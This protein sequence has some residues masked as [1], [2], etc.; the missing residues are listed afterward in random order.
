MEYAVVY[1][2]LFSLGPLFFLLERRAPAVAL[3]RT[4]AAVV[5]DGLYWLLTPIFTGTLSRGLVLGLVGVIG[6]G[7]GHGLD[8]FGFLARVQAAMPF[9]RLPLAA[10][11]VLALLVSDAIGY[12]SHRLRHGALLWNLHSVHHSA[13]ELTALAAARLHPLDEALDSMVMGVPVLLL[14]FP[15]EVFALLGPFFVLHTLLLHANLDWSFGALGKVFASPRFHRRHH[16]RELPTKNF[17]GVFAFFDVLFGT[18]ELP[19]K[20]V[21]V[22]GIVERD[23]PEN[24][25]RQLA[26]PVKRMLR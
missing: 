25:L 10:Q 11:F 7:A 24:L 14:G 9:A 19:E 6:Y 17:G 21:G 12:L 22:F 20:D 2:G 18:F 3:V 4:R 26:Y 13:E 15:L 8:G 5:T 23:V 16:A 1:L